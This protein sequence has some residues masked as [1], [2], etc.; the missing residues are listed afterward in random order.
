MANFKGNPKK[1]QIKHQPKVDTKKVIPITT[2]SNRYYIIIFTIITFILYGNTLFN[3]YSMDDDFVIY[4]NKTVQ[5]GI[6]S[7]PKIFTSLYSEGKLKY[8][9]R[10]VVKAS[11]AIEAQIFG[12]N[13]PGVS[14][15]INI[16][17]Y[18]CTAIMLFYLLKKFL[19]DYNILFTVIIVILFIAHPIHTEVVAS[20]KN[21][22][23][24]ISFLSVLISLHFFVRYV[25][26]KKLWYTLIAMIFYGIGYF[27]KI[28]ILTFIIVIPLVLYF[29]TEAKLKDLIIVFGILTITLLILRIAPRFYLPTPDRD[30]AFF[31]NPLYFEK[32]RIIKVA[33]GL[34]GLLFYIRLLVFPHPLVFYYG[35]N[36][37][38]IVD[39]GNVFVIISLIIHLALFVYAIMKIREK[40][41]LSFVILFYLITISMF[42]NIVK[43]AVGIVAERFIYIS[44][45]S[46]CIAIVYF[47]FK[48]LKIDF[49]IKQIPSNIKNKLFAGIFILLIPYTAKTISRNEDW[50][51]F[52][53]LY[54]TDIEHLSNSAKANTLYA[55]FLLSVVH[56]NPKAPDVQEN[57][58]L[59]IKHYEKAIKIYPQYATS[60]N[61]L[62]SI[63]F[64]F[65][66]DFKSAEP[67][68][69]KAIEAK[70]NYEEACFNLAYTYEKMG[71]VK[72]AKKYYMKTIEIK[73]DY[74]VAYSNLA[75]LVFSTGDPNTAVEINKYAMKVGPLSDMPY[76]NI[77]N[78]SLLSHD[79]IKA[80]AWW[81]VAL[82]KNPSNE[83]LCNSLGNYF[84]S[85]GN[86]QKSDFYFNMENKA[87]RLMQKTKRENEDK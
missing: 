85:K 55:S 81:E 59:A 18:L 15:F 35:Y 25:E 49:K 17:L 57:L 47:I 6:K 22:D 24:L 40:H 16:L 74:L 36:E 23:A 71:K 38:P 87:N 7:I 82:K 54:S 72:R 42:A 52:K 69:L 9:Y 13:S 12:A 78:Y 61:N 33:T 20:L 32:S 48:L 62:G 86:T 84:R 39:F 79:T 70:P 75:N 11:F 58:K 51:D 37:I 56:K 5:G 21:R 66:K 73:P 60:L 45:L 29:F 26:T 10:P 3:K 34:W 2:K 27:S 76:I 31:E 28:D 65:Y 1:K 53:S 8:E 4:Q 63:Y 67:Y 80:V 64:T 14:H 43:P 83:K 44:S 41:L 46:F 30:L 77:G 50:K 68:F 19:K